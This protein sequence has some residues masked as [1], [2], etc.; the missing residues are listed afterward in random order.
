MSAYTRTCAGTCGLRVLFDEANVLP[1]RALPKLLDV[2][3]LATGPQAFMLTGFELADGVEAHSR[4]WCQ[5]VVPGVIRK[6]KGRLPLERAVQ[7]AIRGQHSHERR[8]QA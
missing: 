1:A 8:R 4:G 5:T 2:L 7:V 3:L 6:N